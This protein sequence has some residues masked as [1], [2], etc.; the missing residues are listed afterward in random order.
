LSISRDFFVVDAAGLRYGDYSIDGDHHR[1][2]DLARLVGLEGSV[3][4]HV[5]GER[6]RGPRQY[7]AAR[8]VQLARESGVPVETFGEGGAPSCQR[9]V[10]APG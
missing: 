8:L 2:A 3:E 9:E 6:T 5:V 10:C 7:S 1:S 4:E